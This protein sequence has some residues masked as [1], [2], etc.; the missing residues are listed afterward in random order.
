[1]P[2]QLWKK[3]NSLA[4][5][6][7]CL[8]LQVGFLGAPSAGLA[9]ALWA[10]RPSP[11]RK[12]HVG[13]GQNHATCWTGW[14]FLS[15]PGLIMLVERPTLLRCLLSTHTD[16][17]SSPW[18]FPY[19]SIAAMGTSVKLSQRSRDYVIYRAMNHHDLRLVD[20]QAMDGPKQIST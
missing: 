15:T 11:G 5:T 14:I 12:A 17:S 16:T 6:E 19:F 7:I 20:N 1:M 9:L 4:M 8:Q 18:T 2:S 13:K 3:G 10:L